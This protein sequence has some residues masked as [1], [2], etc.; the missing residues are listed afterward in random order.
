MDIYVVQWASIGP[1]R[2]IFLGG[3]KTLW[4]LLD[5]TFANDMSATSI[6]ILC[7]VTMQNNATFCCS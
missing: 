2:K 3:T 5:F 6:I 4:D 1:P 7:Y